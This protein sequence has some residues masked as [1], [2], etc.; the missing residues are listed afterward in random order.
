VADFSPDGNAGSSSNAVAAE[1]CGWLVGGR[2]ATG[3]LRPGARRDFALNTKRHTNGSFT[4]C[5]RHRRPLGLHLCWRLSHRSMR[6]E[7]QDLK[8]LACGIPKQAD[9]AGALGEGDR[10]EFGVFDVDT[11]GKG[12]TIRHD[13]VHHCGGDD[14]VLQRRFDRAVPLPA[15]T[16]YEERARGAI[17]RTAV[18]QAR[19]CS[20]RRWRVSRA[21]PHRER[22]RWPTLH[23]R[24][25]HG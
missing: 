2:F 15:K 25:I 14:V 3:G 4:D 8:P 9:D 13:C 22:S 20:T 21:T 7:R 1:G 19:P 17:R 16:L 5:N 6:V 10:L 23:L 11:E 24:P 12:G 18:G